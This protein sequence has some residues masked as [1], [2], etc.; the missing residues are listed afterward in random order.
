MPQIRRIPSLSAGLLAA[1]LLMA[2]C[3]EDAQSP[4]SPGAGTTQ[5]TPAVAAAGTPLSFL[6]VSAGGSY[7]CGLTTDSLAYCWGGSS[8][9]PAPVPGGRRFM[10]IS[11]GSGHTCAVTGDDRAYCWGINYDGQ[12]GTGNT[13][14][15]ATPVAVAGGRRFHQIR[16]GDD[17]TCALNL[18]DAAYCW[19]NEEF[20]ELGTGVGPSL[21]PQLVAGGLHYRQV[22]PGVSHTC[23]V[24]TDNR[25]YCWGENSSHQ[26]GDG[27]YTNRFRPSAVIGG[28][29]FQQVVPGD[30]FVVEASEPLVD[31]A[32]TCGITTDGKAYC[33]GYP[34][35]GGSGAQGPIA[36]LGGHLYRFITVGREHACAVA[37]SRAIFCWGSND[38]GELGIGTSTTYSVTPLKVASS[39]LF[40]SVSANALGHHTCALTT[41]HRAYCWGSNSNGQLGDGTKTTRLAPVAVAGTM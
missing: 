1:A 22:I 17:Y 40:S 24:T 19:G 4:S 34:L 2:G 26:L 37:M 41:D 23:G 9:T 20:G 21:T 11:A 31:Q 27:T 35:G 32:F 39:L 38:A 14:A 13:T 7:T 16:A 28:L 30:G 12:L 18:N 36:V 15:S 8:L 25:A 5:A 10:Q 3:Q 29:S 6:Q 33:W